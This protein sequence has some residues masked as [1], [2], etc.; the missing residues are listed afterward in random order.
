VLERLSRVESARLPRANHHCGFIVHSDPKVVAVRFVPMSLAGIEGGD[1]LCLA[2]DSANA[3]NL[4]GLVCH[5]PD[6]RRDIAVQAGQ[7]ESRVLP[8]V[9]VIQR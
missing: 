1:D 2:Y 9:S 4:Y 5:K 8:G 6:E 7:P 3:V